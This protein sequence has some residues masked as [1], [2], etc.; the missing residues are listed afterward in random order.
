M[1]DHENKI[2]LELEKDNNDGRMH[3]NDGE[4]GSSQGGGDKEIPNEY[5]IL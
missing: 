1:T 3:N 5:M 4:A 2:I